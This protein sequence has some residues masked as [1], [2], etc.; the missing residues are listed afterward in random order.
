MKRKIATSIPKSFNIWLFS[1]TLFMPFIYLPY[2]GI[3]SAYNAR[4]LFLLFIMLLALPLIIFNPSYLFSKRHESI[5]LKLLVIYYLFA[6]ISIF[7]ATDKFSA[8]VGGY[9]LEGIILI[10]IYMIIYL[11]SIKITK[12]SKVMIMTVLYSATIICIHAIMQKYKIDPFPASM[13]MDGFYGL[14]FST[15]GNPNFLGSFIAILLPFS[16][17]MY[18]EKNYKYA[19]PIY[20]VLFFALLCSRTRGAW[21]GAFSSIMI[22]LFIKYRYLEFTKDNK[23]KLINVLIASIASI[24]IIALNDQFDFIFR[25]LSIFFDFSNFL[26]DKPNPSS[27]GYIRLV[28]WGRVWEIIK[29]NPVFGIGLENLGQVIENN[30]REYM[31]QKVGYDQFYDMAHNEYLHIAV[32]T[33]IPSLIAYLG[34]VFIALKKSISRIKESDLYLPVTA[35]L[36]GFFTLSMFNNSLIMFEYLVWILLGIAAA[37]NTVYYTDSKI[38]LDMNLE[39]NLA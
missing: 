21:I 3:F 4:F 25:F 28:I 17:Y 5:E 1:I 22:Y 31:I 10:S 33:G 26:K 32:T 13:Y 34:F 27:G 8:I 18:M 16:I 15:M 11:A 6:L 38:E 24:I 37:T 23:S 7:F 35:S 30:Y 20:T 2:N 29:Q 14:A 19:L 39:K 36:I 12:L 9:R